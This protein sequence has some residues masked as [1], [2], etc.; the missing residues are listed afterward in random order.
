MNTK[1]KIILGI[2][3]I[4]MFILTVIGVTYAYFVTRVEVEDIAT[5]VVKTA[6]IGTAYQDNNQNIVVDNVL[7]GKVVYKTFVVNNKSEVPVSYA[8]TLAS[9]R[10]ESEV[11]GECSESGKTNKTDCE[12]V[13]GTWIGVTLPSFVHSKLGINYE[14]RSGTLVDT[15]Y[16]GNSYQ[17]KPLECYNA[18]SY[19]NILVELYRV[20]NY[21]SGVAN[22]INDSSLQGY[23]EGIA[24]DLE[25]NPSL[26]DS[27]ATCS[28]YSEDAADGSYKK[29]DVNYSD[30]SGNSI[31]KIPVSTNENY[32]LINIEAPYCD[33]VDATCNPIGIYQQNNKVLEQVAAGTNQSNYYVLKV[34]YQNVNVNQNIEN[35]AS[36]SLKVDIS[37]SAIQKSTLASA[38]LKNGAVLTRQVQKQEFVS[39]ICGETY[40][41][42][43]ANIAEGC[44]GSCD[45]QTV[46][47]DEP[48][49]DST[50]KSTVNLNNVANGSSFDTA[51]TSFT[52]DG[53]FKTTDDSGTT[54]YFRGPVENNY[55]DFADMCWRIVSITSSGETKLVL[56]DKDDLCK[57]SDQNW[58]IPSATG[59]MIANFGYTVSTGYSELEQRDYFI[60]TANYLNPE[61]DAENAMVNAFKKFQTS[62]T[63]DELDYMQF[64]NWCSDSNVSS[65]KCQNPVMDYYNDGTKMY[66]GTLTAYEG[67][68]SGI[69]LDRDVD[70]HYL[71]T[72]GIGEMGFMSMTYFGPNFSFGYD[73]ESS[74]VFT[75]YNNTSSIIFISDSPANEV[76]ASHELRPVIQLQAN[77]ILGSGN[78]TKNNAY[79]L[80]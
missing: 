46:T 6:V 73:R 64:G 79:K 43:V 31:I 38:V 34:T 30:C 51:T 49:T 13:G 27:W 53:L 37:A 26:F 59:E 41:E 3:A 23:N 15:C 32:E 55:V 54:Y 67:I 12:A 1:P 5:A 60:Y 20:E 28:Y 35:D 62:F 8:I 57:D 36:V 52:N 11:S 17:T 10:N 29:G 44:P 69:P 56:E 68:L 40:D 24:L 65:L 71:F 72:K 61:V 45:F 39:G 76:T 63:S 48:F 9:K 33:S 14:N 2:S 4:F 75:F 58:A 78:G 74:G 19:D 7:P 80:K 50:I 22:F 47:V 21:T 16:K 25:K 70:K 42:C 18:D 77:V 66:V